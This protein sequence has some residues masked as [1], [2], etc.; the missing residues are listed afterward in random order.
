MKKILSILAAISLSATPTLSVVACGNGDNGYSKLRDLTDENIVLF[1]D[2]VGK[3]FSYEGDFVFLKD[4]EKIGTANSYN[5]ISNL[6][7]KKINELMSKKFKTKEKN[8][9]GGVFFDEKIEDLK[10]LEEYHFTGYAKFVNLE[11]RKVITI[12]GLNFTFKQTNDI[13]VKDIN[14]KILKDY[15]GYSNNYTSN[16]DE[17]LTWSLLD[18][19]RLEEPIKNGEKDKV[20]DELDIALN[21][22]YYK[23]NIYKEYEYKVVVSDVERYETGLKYENQK[24]A[25]VN[26]SF[27]FSNLREAKT[28]ET[29][30]VMST[31]MVYS[32]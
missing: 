14:E 8:Y 16:N 32:N 6:F 23:T 1:F 5:L 17:S 25:R 24:F 28:I 3:D 30:F 19:F 22:D 29:S 12:K 9:M 7:I 10:P 21:D 31:R 2:E 13:S 18:E 11:T 20:R 4:A 27:T 26:A 15:L